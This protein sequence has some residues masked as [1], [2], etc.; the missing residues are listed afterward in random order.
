MPFIQTRIT[1]ELSESKKESLHE[2]VEKIVQE[3]LGKPVAYIMV[4][5]EDNYNLYMGGKKLEKGAMISL[6]QFGAPSKNA[7]NAITKRLCDYL[8]KE[9]GIEGSHVYVT[10]ECI[11]DWGWNGSLF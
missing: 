6:Q 9:L 11:N 7:F 10:F 1:T 3:E 8:E 5:I 2:A 4:G